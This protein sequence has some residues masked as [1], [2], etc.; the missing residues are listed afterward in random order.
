MTIMLQLPN[1][2][3]IALSGI[4]HK[5][6]ENAD[7][8]RKSCERV[9]FGAVKYIQLGN[10]VDIS[11]WNRA[12]IFDLP[13][14][15][16]TDFALLIHGDGYVIH[17]ECWNNRWLE[18]DYIGAPWPLP[19]DDYSY[20]D[21]AGN[22]VRVGN[23]VSLRSKKLLDLVATRPMQFHHGN[24]NED[25][26][27]CCW[28]RNWLESQGCKFAPVSMAVHFSKEHT[29]DENRDIKKTFAFHSL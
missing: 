18:Y 29:I 7:A 19:G 1:V 23:S 12:I 28:N 22:L 3:L 26:Q 8:L 21:E 6:D 2:T 17:P 14:Y 5:A 15:V 20:R 24:N 13:K 10:V 11:S 9:E 16:E 25:G 27:I 4:G